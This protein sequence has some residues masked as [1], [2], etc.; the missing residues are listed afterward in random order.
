MIFLQTSYISKYTDKI[1]E[2]AMNCYQL[3]SSPGGETL[4]LFIMKK[5]KIYSNTKRKLK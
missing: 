5:K 3:W 2:Y 4:D 1:E